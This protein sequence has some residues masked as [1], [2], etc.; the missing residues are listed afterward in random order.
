[1]DAQKENFFELR[2][3]VTLQRKGNLQDVN[4]GLCQREKFGYA[5]SMNAALCK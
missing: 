2:S 1:M 3:R 4:P 5:R